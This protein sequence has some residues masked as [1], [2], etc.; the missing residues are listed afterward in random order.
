MHDIEIKAVEMLLRQVNRVHSLSA[1]MNATQ[2]RQ[3]FVCEG[4]NTKAEP[5]DTCAA[6]IGES[7][8]FSTTGVGFHGDLSP[9]ANTPSLINT[10]EQPSD[11][12]S[13]K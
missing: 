7:R 10:V 9:C 4:L 6:V 1:V 13:A 3:L 11:A 2:G 5:V 12:G 8:S